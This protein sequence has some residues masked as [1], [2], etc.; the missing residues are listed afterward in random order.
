MY[1][2]NLILSEKRSEGGDAAFAWCA[3]WYWSACCC[4]LAGPAL[5]Y[6][7]IDYVLKLSS[8]TLFVY[9]W[10]VHYIDKELK[11]AAIISID[12]L[13]LGCTGSIISDE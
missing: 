7:L 5:L 8:D 13:D 10:N 3:A 12:I 1:G 9:Y 4:V 6:L 2:V 11:V